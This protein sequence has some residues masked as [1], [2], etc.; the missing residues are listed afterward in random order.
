MKKALMHKDTVVAT[1]SE[2]K[3]GIN[4]LNIINKELFPFFK[5]RTEINSYNM[6]KLL[7]STNTLRKDIQP[8]AGF[9]GTDKYVSSNLAGL[10]DCYYI[11]NESDPVTFEDITPFN[12]ED[13]STDPIYLSV[14]KPSEFEQSDFDNTSPNLCIPGSKPVFWYDY[15]DKTTGKT[16]RGYINKNAQDD[17]YLYKTASSHDIDIVKERKY[18][19]IHNNIYTFI[20]I[21]TSKDIERLSFEMLYYMEYDPKLSN[22]KNIANVCRKL[23][24]KDWK[25][26][27]Q[28]MLE[29]NK[30]IR[31]PL[32]EIYVFRDA[33]TGEYL[34]FDKI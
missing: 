1:F 13:L 15:I 20:P 27:I 12:I 24:I 10:N 11:K 33:N 28:K 17:M 34:S 3:E 9:Y 32:S 2:T 6:F 18:V 25:D 23:D 26:Y 5:N 19:I 31:I 8:F 16:E 7:R 22:G 14:V 21:S 4:D 30:L 29:L